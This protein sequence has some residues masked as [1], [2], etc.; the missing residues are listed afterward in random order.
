MASPRFPA[1]SGFGCLLTKY[2]YYILVHFYF[3]VP[4]AKLCFQTLRHPGMQHSLFFLRLVVCRLGWAL[5]CHDVTYCVT[6]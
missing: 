4:L 2:D 5:A 3:I 1:I 6:S